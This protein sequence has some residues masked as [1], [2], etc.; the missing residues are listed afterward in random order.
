MADS[1]SLQV[2]H[3]CEHLTLIGSP[4]NW[5]CF[6]YVKALK[7]ED[8]GNMPSPQ[9]FTLAGVSHVLR[10]GS[11]DDVLTWT[12][13]AVARLTKDF[14]NLAFVPI[15]ASTAAVGSPSAGRTGQ[16]A[17]A[18]A[19][20][21]SGARFADVLR[22]REVRQSSHSGGGTRDPNELFQNLIL[23]GDIYLNEYVVLIDDV[24]TTGAHLAAATRLLRAAGAWVWTGVVAARA[25]HSRSDGHTFQVR[26]EIVSLG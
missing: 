21:H 17:A 14:G 7:G 3:L 11:P 23:T 2:V 5:A 8:M 19:A 13:E 22:W 12:G 1:D 10:K 20:A 16:I 6:W 4:R 9:A 18:A 25:V 15:P 24:L 26:R